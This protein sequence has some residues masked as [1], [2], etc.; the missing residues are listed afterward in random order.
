[1]LEDQTVTGLVSCWAAP[2]PG[3]DSFGAPVPFPPPIHELPMAR[4]SG[5]PH[6]APSVVAGPP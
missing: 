1:M 6:A 5:W 2:A 3:R 4:G